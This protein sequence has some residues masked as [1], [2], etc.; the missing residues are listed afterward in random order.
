MKI[1][2]FFSVMLMLLCLSVFAS[3]FINFLDTVINLESY[4]NIGLCVSTPT[5]MYVKVPAYN[6]TYEIR[7]SSYATRTY[8]ISYPGLEKNLSSMFFLN[9]N[10]RWGPFKTSSYLDMTPLFDSTYP[11]C[12]VK[13]SSFLIFDIIK[14]QEDAL[15]H[16]LS[17]G[18]GVEYSQFFIETR[19]NF[20]FTKHSDEPFLY[21]VPPH[22]SAYVLSPAAVLEYKFKGLCMSFSVKPP[23][24]IKRLHTNKGYCYYRPFFFEAT[25]KPEYDFMFKDVVANLSV[26]DF[27]FD[28]SLSYGFDF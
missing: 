28:F 5:T 23:F 15:S 11:M 24:M 12:L 13:T 27:Q 19:K 22:I 16:A 2:L 21:A 3:P 6:D 18:F 9:L 17:I 25:K 1:F 7:E 10:Y 4:I 14:Q 8:S 20:V 26:P